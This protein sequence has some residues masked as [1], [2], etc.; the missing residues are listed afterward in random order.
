M[1]PYRKRV[2]TLILLVLGAVA[3]AILVY[4]VNLEQAG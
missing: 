1:E 2:E 4:L 3:V